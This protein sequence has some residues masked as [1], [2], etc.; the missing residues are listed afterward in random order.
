V[1]GKS[2]FSPNLSTG[3]II[4]RQ[5]EQHLKLL[6]QAC[7]TI[8]KNIKLIWVVPL[9]L[10]HGGHCTHLGRTSGKLNSSGKLY[11]KLGPGGRC[12]CR[13]HWQT[14]H[15]VNG[16]GLCLFFLMELLT[17]PYTL[18]TICR[19]SRDYLESR[20]PSNLL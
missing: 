8:R 16:S 10:R 19:P 3:E 17:M 1:V 7:V 13:D 4:Y 5:K 6:V 15:S 2:L 14:Q 18:N 20:S 11:A 9:D 12:F